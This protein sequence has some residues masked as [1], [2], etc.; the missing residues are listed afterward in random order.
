MTTNDLFDG[1]VVRP[2][3]NWSDVKLSAQTQKIQTSMTGNALFPDQQ[4]L[5]P[6]FAGAVN[7]Y[8]LQLA[9]AG[10]RDANAIAAKNTRRAALIALCVQLG[11]SVTG[12]ANGDVEALVSTGLPLRKKRQSRVLTAPSNLRLTPGLNSGELE[13]RVDGM[14]VAATY[15]FE[16]T[17][18]SQAKGIGSGRSWSVA[19]D[20][21]LPAT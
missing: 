10:S 1:V 19:K 2:Y 11:N 14:K 17:A 4:T 21:K 3:K 20:S 5:M 18:C 7:A 9:K 13:A 16:Y 6:G 15:G 8:V 12:T